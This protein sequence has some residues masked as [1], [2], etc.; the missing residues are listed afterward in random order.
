M[1]TSRAID[2]GFDTQSG[3]TKDYK[4][5][6]SVSHTALR[7]QDINVSGWIIGSVNYHYKNPDQGGSLERNRHNP[8]H[9]ENGLFSPW[10]S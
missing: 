7:R 10:Y 3:K 6:C 8:Y 5:V 1:L 9:I 2:H 4:L